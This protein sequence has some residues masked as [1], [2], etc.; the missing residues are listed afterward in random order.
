MYAVRRLKNK[1]INDYIIKDN[2]YAVR[3]LQNNKKLIKLY[4][5]MCMQSGGYKTNV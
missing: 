2:V 3:R 4:G 1:C 5:I